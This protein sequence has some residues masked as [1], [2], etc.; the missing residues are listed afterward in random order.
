MKYFIDTEF[1]EGTQDKTFLGLKVGTTKPIIDLISIALV[2]DDNREYYA[3]SKDFN[4]KEAWNRFDLVTMT[5]IGGIGDTPTQK[6]V[7][8]IRENVL[9]PIWEEKCKEGFSFKDSPMTP[10][11]IKTL[12]TYKNFKYLINKYG[13]TN[14]QIS[15][16]IFEFVNPSSGE[17]TLNY[18]SWNRHLNKFKVLAYE[19]LPIEFYGFMSAYDHVALCW[20]FGKM[21]DL[22]KGFPMYTIDLQQ[23]LDRKVSELKNNRPD[24]LLCE[25]LRNVEYPTMIERDNIQEFYDYPK[26]T[27]EHN[28]LSDAKFNKQLYEFLQSL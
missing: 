21:I 15:D 27:N 9:R 10:H 7:Y 8:W 2:S 3:I 28:A 1:L 26:Q 14:E 4:L 18:K 6:K 13:K 16:E 17:D 5:N 12:F 22:P 23:E 20:L 25:R 19:N 11:G 24:G